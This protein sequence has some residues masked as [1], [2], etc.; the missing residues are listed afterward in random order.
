MAPLE[1]SLSH[2]SRHMPPLEPGYSLSV[3]A[4]SRVGSLASGDGNPRRTNHTP[5]SPADK[6]FL[7]GYLEGVVKEAQR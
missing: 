6:G 5:I 3:S 7:L 1:P 2:S 4:R